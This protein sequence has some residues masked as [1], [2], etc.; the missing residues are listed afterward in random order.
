M[1]MSS[2]PILCKIPSTRSCDNFVTE[3]TIKQH[4]AR[5]VGRAGMAGTR[6]SEQCR[7]RPRLQV[8]TGAPETAL[9]C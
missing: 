8:S 3:R 6:R 1:S 9:A 4:G 2:Q 5:V 7:A